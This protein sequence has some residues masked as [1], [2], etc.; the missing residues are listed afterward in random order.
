MVAKT[1]RNHVEE[2]RFQNLSLKRER[3]YIKILDFIIS[4]FN[5][6]QN[7]LPDVRVERACTRL[8]EDVIDMSSPH[9]RVK[10]ALGFLLLFCNFFLSKRKKVNKINF[11]K[12]QGVLTP[13]PSLRDTFSAG[14]GYFLKKTIE[15]AFWLFQESRYI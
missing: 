8:F 3:I 9:K 13:L 2:H 14:E 1:T 5:E 6:S 7:S 10:P 12:T 4:R 11:V 15:S